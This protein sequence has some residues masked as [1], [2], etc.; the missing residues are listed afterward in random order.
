MV[1]L[2]LFPFNMAQKYNDQKFRSFDMKNCKG[3]KPTLDDLFLHP[4]HLH[5][6]LGNFIVVSPQYG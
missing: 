1:I 2:L 3:Y 6:I 4:N 5:I